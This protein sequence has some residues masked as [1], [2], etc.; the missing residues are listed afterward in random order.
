MLLSGLNFPDRPVD[1]IFFLLRWRE[2]KG[3]REYVESGFLEL[4]AGLRETVLMDNS[5]R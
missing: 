5:D 4:L 2:E 3:N 1:L